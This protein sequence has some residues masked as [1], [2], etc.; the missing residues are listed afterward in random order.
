MAV[1]YPDNVN[2]RK[3]RIP[4]RRVW[5]NVLY[6]YITSRC[7]QLVL[8]SLLRESIPGCKRIE[9]D[10]ALLRALRGRNREYL[11]SLPSSL[12]SLEAS[13]DMTFGLRREKVLANEAEV[14]PADACKS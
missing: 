13:I 4:N 11:G 8:L 6:T 10:R 3:R 12:E 9:T 14:S 1:I 7:I 5:S 2:Q